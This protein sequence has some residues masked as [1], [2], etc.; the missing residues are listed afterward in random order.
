MF[1]IARAQFYGGVVPCTIDYDLGYNAGKDW[2]N[3]TRTF[4]QGL[5]N[6]YCRDSSGSANT[7]CGT[8]SQVTSGNAT[9]TA[10]GAVTNQTTN[11]LGHFISLGR[12]YQSWTFDQALDTNNQ[13]IAWAAAGDIETLRFTVA[14]GGENQHFFMLVPAVPALSPSQPHAFP[15]RR[16][17][18]SHVGYLCPVEHQRASVQWQWDGGSGG[19]NWTNIAG[20]TNFAYSDVPGNVPTNTYQYRLAVSNFS[21]NPTYAATALSSAPATITVAGPTAPLVVVNPVSIITYLSNITTFAGS[22][23]APSRSPPS[24]R[25]APTE[26]QHRPSFPTRQTS[27]PCR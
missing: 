7:N 2:M 5:Y 16:Q 6:I 24:G 8:I 17:R 9:T 11:Y 4:P 26:E 15:R 25:S 12:G 14:G 22:F 21:A 10:G 23:R 19:V 1:D 20:E 27:P 13:V 3:Y 18:H